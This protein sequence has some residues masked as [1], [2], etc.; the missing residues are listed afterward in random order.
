[1]SEGIK[2]RRATINDVDF[3]VDTI[4]AA[5]KSGTDNFGLAKLFELSEGEMRS[6]IKAMLEEEVDGCE[7]SVSSFLVAEH[8]GRVVSAFAGWMEGQNE[9]G[10]SSAILKSNLLGYCLPMK[11]VVKSQTKSDVVRHLQIEREEGTYQLE[12]SYT[13]P[14]YRGKGIMKDI[15]NMHIIDCQQN[16]PPIQPHRNQDGGIRKIQ[17]H[18]FANNEAAIGTYKRCGFEITKEFNSN[19]PLVEQYFPYHTI[20]L[21]ERIV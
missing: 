21:M 12:Y 2:I 6:Y 7:F 14:E 9:E 10:L 17:V 13:L 11:N 5:E 4:V 18:V 8:Q 3:L 19:N 20:L 1:M 16:T 15:I